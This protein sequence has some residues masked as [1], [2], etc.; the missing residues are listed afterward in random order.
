[1]S[2]LSKDCKI[3]YHFPIL[4]KMNAMHTYFMDCMVLINL[5]FCTV[6]YFADTM[7]T[8]YKVFSLLTMPPIY[9]KETISISSTTILIQLIQQ[10]FKFR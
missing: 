4:G 2:D 7:H 6:V 9:F 10:L 1:M 8:Y 3:L 5:E